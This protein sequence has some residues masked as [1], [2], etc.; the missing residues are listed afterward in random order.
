[1]FEMAKTIEDKARQAYSD[2]ISYYQYALMYSK[3]REEKTFRKGLSLILKVLK[4]KKL[5]A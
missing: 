4:K 1:V 2:L 5:I 3:G